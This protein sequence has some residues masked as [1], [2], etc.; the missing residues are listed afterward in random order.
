MLLWPALLIALLTV[1]L[2]ILSPPGIEAYRPYLAA[3][4]IG[5]WSVAAFTLWFSLQAFARCHLA[6]LWLQLPF[7]EVFIPYQDIQ[8]TRLVQFGRQF[9]PD[10]ENWSRRRFLEPLFF[11]AVVIVELR[12][13]PAPRRQ[14]HLW[15][16]RHL[17]SPDT[18]GF[19]LPVRDWLGFR[20][21]LDEFRS[22][23]Y[24]LTQHK[25]R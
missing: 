3:A 22:R 5:G 16:S 15:M 18:P 13:L 4:G 23:S 2:F 12:A 14:L 25:E 24:S 10:N 6:G 17:L 21:E 11:R 19:M 20:G 9:P 7:Y 8:S 1:L